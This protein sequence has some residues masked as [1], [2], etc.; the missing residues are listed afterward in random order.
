MRTYT[1]TYIP[2]NLCAK[3]QECSRENYILISGAMTNL[4]WNIPE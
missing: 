2:L 1:M 4:F 3:S